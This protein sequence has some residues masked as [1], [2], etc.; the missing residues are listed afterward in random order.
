MSKKIIITPMEEYS[1]NF[2]NIVPASEFVP[3]WY[4]KSSSNI[5][6][7]KSEL[8]I[9]NPSTTNATYKK[10][11]P[12]FDAISAGYMAYL[13]ADIEVIRKDDGMPFIMWR[14]KRDIVTHHDMPQWDG[15]PCP[16]GYSPFVYK[17]HNQFNIK[18]PEDY[19]LLFL[20]PIN[21]FDLPF[22]TVTGIVDCDEYTGSVQFPFF[23]KN[24]FVGIIEKG[25]PITQIIPIKRDNW[26]REYNDYH[27]ST[28]TLHQ[29]SFLS[30]IKR[31]YKNNYWHRKEYN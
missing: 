14:T 4:R 7:T 11:T 9:T 5:A 21:R 28:K 18:T 25:T 1:D 27:K 15:L 20:S 19:S 23:I 17:W 16:E 2:F 26:N 6:G 3:E 8:H 13:T 30:T 22:L 31:S 24:N 10:C 29:E 12:F